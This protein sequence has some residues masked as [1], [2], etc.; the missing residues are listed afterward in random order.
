[1]ILGTRER[2]SVVWEGSGW[3]TGAIG[4]CGLAGAEEGFARR[5]GVGRHLQRG[6]CADCSSLLLADPGWRKGVRP[7]TLLL[8]H[9]RQ[10]TGKTISLHSGGGTYSKSLFKLQQLTHEMEV[11]GNTR[12]LALDKVIGRPEVIV[13]ALHDVGHGDCG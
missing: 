8:L 7:L 3:K 9:T 13:E 12:A 6:R 4:G 2:S 11:G 5:N 10:A 1:M